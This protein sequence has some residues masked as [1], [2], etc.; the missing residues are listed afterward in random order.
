VIVAVIIAALFYGTRILNEALPAAASA[1]EGRDAIRLEKGIVALDLFAESFGANAFQLAEGY[2]D[3]VL[4][5][6]STQFTATA[7]EAFT[8]GSGTPGA[9]F[10]YQGLFTGVDVAIEGEVTVLFDDGLG[11]V[12]DAWTRQ[13]VLDGALGEV[14]EMVRSIEIRP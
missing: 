5:A 10:R 8:S 9:R 13:G 7:I 1:R 12:A 4:A 3:E 2:R 6:G 11:I 14:H